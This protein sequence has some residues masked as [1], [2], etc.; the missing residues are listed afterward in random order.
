M[1]GGDGRRE[2]GRRDWKEERKCSG[3]RGEGWEEGG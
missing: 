1:E 3:M 2:Q